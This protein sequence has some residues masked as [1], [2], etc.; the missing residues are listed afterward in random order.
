MNESAQAVN[1]EVRFTRT[2]ST[3]SRVRYQA[4]RWRL[5]ARYALNHV[6]LRATDSRLVTLPTSRVNT[7]SFA[8]Q[9][10]ATL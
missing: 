3:L 9:F 7:V 8:G 2:Y 6:G 5:L 10:A 4:A 1:Q